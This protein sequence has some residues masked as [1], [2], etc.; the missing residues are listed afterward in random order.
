[1]NKK[2]R[3]VLFESFLSII[4]SKWKG[5]E[6]EWLLTRGYWFMLQR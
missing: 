1:M 4:P 6:I 3:V 2:I 5:G